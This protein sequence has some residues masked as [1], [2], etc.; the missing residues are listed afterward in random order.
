MARPSALKTR[1]GRPTPGAIPMNL[2]SLLLLPAA[3]LALLA[4]V[5]V[6]DAA[7]TAPTYPSISKIDPLNLAIGETMTITG[8]GFVKGK[9]RNTVVFK[10]GNQRAIF[11]K[12]LSATSTKLKVVVPEKVRPFLNKKEGAEVP[13]KFR[14]RV[15][16][17]RF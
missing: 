11:A 14:L 3:V 6:A 4:P 12:A 17:R 5:A 7:T 8:R 9:N 13:T 15:L 10:R 2:R 1:R 16:A